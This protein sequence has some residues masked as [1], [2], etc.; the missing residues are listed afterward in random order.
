NE[1]PVLKKALIF[2]G[3]TALKKCY[4]GNYRF[5]EDLDYTVIDKNMINPNIL[6]DEFKK[7]ATWIYEQSGLRIANERTDFDI[8]QNSKG[9]VNCQGRLYYQGPISPTSQRQWPRIN[10]DFTTEEL[11]VQEPVEVSILHDYDDFDSTVFKATAYCFEEVLA[12]KIRAIE[13]RCM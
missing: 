4:F 2:K 5:S 9:L 10:L 7:V 1:N 13:E 11:V 8:Y 12:E 3:G 6:L